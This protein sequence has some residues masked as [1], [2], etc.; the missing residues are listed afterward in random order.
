MYKLNVGCIKFKA[1]DHLN[2]IGRVKNGLKGV[3][4]ELIDR[5]GQLE[6]S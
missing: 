4:A 2:Q 6:S 1:N 5:K 3:R